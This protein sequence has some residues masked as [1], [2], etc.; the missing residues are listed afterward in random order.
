M[1]KKKI[2]VGII[3]LKPGESQTGVAPRG[4]FARHIIS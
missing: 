4:E 2:N 3:G 1:S